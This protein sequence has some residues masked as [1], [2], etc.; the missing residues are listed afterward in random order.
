MAEWRYVPTDLTVADD[1][2]KW[3]GL[4]N[5]KPQARWFN[6]PQF[7]YLAEDHWPCTSK[8]SQTTELEL[9]PSAMA[10]FIASDPIV[11]VN[12]FSNWGRLVRVVAFVQRFSNNCKLKRL[13]QSIIS[14]PLSSSEISSAEAYLLRQ[15][16]LESYPEEVA[17]FQRSQ[18]EPTA[19]KT[20]LPKA[21][22]LHQKSPW[23]DQNGV[24][25]MRGRITNC[26]YATE[27]A[28]NPIILPRDHPTTK[29]IIAHFHQKFHHQNHET[30]INEIRQKYSIPKLRTTFTN[31]RN[32]CQRCKN[33]RVIPRVPIMADLP[34]ARLHV[35]TRPFTHVGVD[36][37]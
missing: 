7:L 3:K 33:H 9:R 17:L 22:P 32:N 19:H 30:V 36:F 21:S 20:P 28:K 23:L 25:R 15:A 24:L 34:V 1:G 11:Q 37:F 31:V 14:C 10:H 16:Q 6:G 4:P 18:H 8:G 29:L 13:K 27:D 26:D 12:D 2:T 35:F 5:L